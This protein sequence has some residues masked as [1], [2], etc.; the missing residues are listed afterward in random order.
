MFPVVLVAPCAVH[1]VEI[2]LQRLHHHVEASP[3][4]GHVMPLAQSSWQTLHQYNMDVV[5]A[6]IAKNSSLQLLCI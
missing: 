2:I 6:I 4:L 3:L 5:P 1:D